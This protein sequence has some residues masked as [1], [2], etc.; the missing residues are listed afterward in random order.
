M[1][2]YPSILHASKAPR[3]PCIAFDKLDGSNL[4][5][6]WT[7]KK[8]FNLFGTRKQIIDETAPFW[9]Q[10][11]ALFKRDIEGVAEDLIRK[12]FP[13][14]RQITFFFEFFGPNSFAGRHDEN[15]KLQVVVFDILVGHKQRKFVPPRHFV[16]MCDKHGIPRPL[17]VYEGNLTD[18]FINRVKK[19]ELDH[20]LQEGVVCKGTEPTGAAAGGIWMAKI[21]TNRWIQKL[22]SSVDNWE[23]YV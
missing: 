16:K 9:N 18:G 2:Q 12:E 1:V 8:G 15:D 11:I 19:E 10:G 17:V 3:K 23:Q 20:K 7:D 21:K 6:K 14:E 22:K 5:A 13:R 4:R